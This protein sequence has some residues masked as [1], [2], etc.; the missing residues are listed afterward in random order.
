MTDLSASNHLFHKYMKDLF[1]ISFNIILKDFSAM[2]Y[3]VFESHIVLDIPYLKYRNHG[4]K[5]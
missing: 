2:C 1:I 3:V 5:K 4:R